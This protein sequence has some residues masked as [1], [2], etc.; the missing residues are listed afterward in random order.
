MTNFGKKKIKSADWFEAHIETMVPAIEEKRKALAAIKTYATE[1]ELQAL[2][3]A[4]SN[5]QRCARR[6][7]NEYWLDL[8]ACIHS[9]VKTGII[10]AIYVRWNQAG[11]LSFSEQ[12]SRLK[13]ATGGIIQERVQ[14]ME[15]WVEHYP[16]LYTR[17]KM[18]SEEAKNAI[19]CKPVVE[20]LDSEPTGEDLEKALGSLPP[21]K[22]PGQDGIRAEILKCCKCVA[23]TELYQIVCLCWREG[24]YQKT[25]ETQT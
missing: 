23:F 21:E 15:R 18:M 1:K 3:S 14:Q 10:K 12:N 4:H 17:E 13:T 19:E 8:C 22:A 24:K 11:T 9:G 16:E 7:A 2:Q 5:V 25:R 20:D 6:C